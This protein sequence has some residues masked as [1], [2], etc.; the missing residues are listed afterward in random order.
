MQKDPYDMTHE[1]FDACLDKNTSPSE[2]FRNARRI[3]RFLTE[4]F[5]VDCSDSILR[6]QA[7]EWW[8]KKTTYPY[9]EI[10]DEW[11]NQ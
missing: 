11:M 7:F 8:A 2:I 4:L 1:E 9:S 6:E 10:Y 5:E 3:Y